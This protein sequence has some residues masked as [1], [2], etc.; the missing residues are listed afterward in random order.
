MPTCGNG[1]AQ[2]REQCDGSDLDGAT[3]VTLGY[4]SG[5]LSCRATCSFDVTGCTSP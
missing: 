1:N 3:C 5:A 4:S 2:Q